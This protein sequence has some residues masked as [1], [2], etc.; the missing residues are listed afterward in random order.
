LQTAAKDHRKITALPLAFAIF[1]LVS[2]GPYGLEPLLQHAGITLGIILI[3]VTPL[4]WGIPISLMTAELS[5]AIP[6]EG[7][8][9][10]WVKRAMG[11]F[12]GFMC[13]WLSW[14][15]SIVD[16]ALYPLL[17]AEY[18]SKSLDHFFKLSVPGFGTALIA[19]S[20]I[21][22]VTYLNIKGIRTVGFAATILTIL[23]VAPFILLVAKSGFHLPPL[24]KPD[25]SGT[26]LSIGLATVLWNYLGWDNLST[27]SGEVHKPQVSYRIALALATPLIT[28]VYLLPVLSTIRVAKLPDRWSDGSWPQIAT[29][30]AG[31]IIGGAVLLGGLA[32]AT[33]MFVS[34]MLASS[35]IPAVMAEDRFLPRGLAMI[36]P[37][38][39]TPVRSILFCAGLYAC[40]SWFSFG[41]LITA[42]A[43]LYGLS[44]LLEMV[45]LIVLR[46]KEPNLVR[47]FRIRGGYPVLVTMTL[48]PLGL[49]L[50]L[51]VTTVREEGWIKQ[52][53]SMIAVLLGIGTYLVAKKRLEAQPV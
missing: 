42:N 33:A 16:A 40:L 8:Y 4:L 11:P 46:A 53:P 28:I 39:G 7:G 50:L 43:F 19:I 1:C 27:V 22:F 12:A 25:F 2:G 21:L 36:N 30:A 49:I 29:A 31:P 38:T 26:A 10:V 51:S 41:E 6:A 15:Y 9:Y 20:L 48:L 24:D 23:I 13:A 32:S 44:I 45:A 47:P 18:V 37:K 3:L 5:S 34:Q 17:F 52:I 14:L 35:R